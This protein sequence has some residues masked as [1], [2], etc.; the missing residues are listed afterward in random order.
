MKAEPGR[1]ARRE[2][3]VDALLGRYSPALFAFFGYIFS[4]ALKRDFRAVR[5]SKAG[6]PPG[7]D[8]SR[9]I[10]YSNHPSWWDAVICVWLGT[11]IFKGRRIFAPMEKAMVERY[12]FMQRIGAFGIDR[13][14]REGSALFLTAAARILADSRD[15][16]LITAQGKF[17]DTRVRPLRLAPG[18]AHVAGLDPQATFV[19]L[20]LD[21]AFWDE[22]QP[23]VFLR[24]GTGIPA[25]ALAGMT[26]DEAR[27][28]LSTALEE[29]MDGL[30][31]DVVARDACAFE[32]LL[33]GRV[34]VGGIYDLWRRTRATVT[35]TEFRAAHGSEP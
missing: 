15:I 16:L 12:R 2:A 25:S 31:R 1:R 4:R 22:R 24:F 30:A 7:A 17:V 11:T 35:G 21:Y 19:P 13:G 26:R 14:T 5:L 10:L 20:A 34:G 29:T 9:I 3:E 27:E 33:A 23:E 6:P 18:I 8:V 28:R 32:T